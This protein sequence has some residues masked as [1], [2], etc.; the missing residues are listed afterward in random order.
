MD[1]HAA[2]PARQQGGRHRDLRA[3]VPSASVEQEKEERMLAEVEVHLR[4]DADFISP[5]IREVSKVLAY[6][7]VPAVDGTAD[8]REHRLELDV[9]IAV[10]DERVDVACVERLDDAAMELHVLLRNRRSPRRSGHWLQRNVP[11]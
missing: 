7:I 3:A 4:F 5:C 2:A 1:D 9:R 6:A 11:A 8:R 10:R